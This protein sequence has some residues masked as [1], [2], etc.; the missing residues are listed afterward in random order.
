M[1]IKNKKSCEEKERRLITAALPYINNLP[2]L[3]HIVGSHLPADIFARYCRLRGYKTLFVGGTDENGSASEIVAKQVGVR[4]DIFCKRLHKEHK[5]IYDWF[6][7]S[8]DNF[9]RTSELIHHQTTQEFFKKIYK[10][11][12][13][14]KDKIKVFYSPEEKMFLPD[15]Y[16][17]GTCAKCGYEDAN[18]D[19]CEKC[20]SVLEV[21]QL[22]SPRSTIS[23]KPVEIRGTQHLFLRLDKLAK[24]LGRWLKEKN[25]WSPQV[26]SLALGWI[27]E[28]LKK[29]SITRD[30]KHGVKVPLKGFENKVFYVWFDAPIGYISSTKE[31]DPE[32][33]EIWWKEK[34]SKIYH[35]LGKDNIP[36]HT[37]FW[38]AMLIAHGEF[39]LP[40]YVVGLQYLN[41]EGKKFSK[42]KKWGVFCENLPKT[43]IDPDIVRAYLTLIIPETKDTEFRWQDFQNSINS[44]IIGNLGNFINRTLSFIYN[45]LGRKIKKP[46]QNELLDSDKKLLETIR[47][48]INKIEIYLENVK[49]RLAFLEILSLSAYGNKY[50][51]N[52]EPWH[53][54]KKDPIRA[55]HI[56]YLCANLCKTLAILI[57][58]YLP[59]ISQKIW[60]Q[61]N[62]K[63][64]I[65]SRGIW[66][67]LGDL[68]LPDSHIINKPHILFKK[69][70]NKDWERFKK[71]VSETKPLTELF[72]SN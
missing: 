31:A 39:N 41:F 19:Q 58:P 10:N 4:I 47:K 60:K 56:L 34:N 17:K 62:L 72:N 51:N 27:R 48:K 25:Y 53:V 3:G 63:E 54:I 16:V 12:F 20:T 43:N 29:R 67:S 71:I 52:N 28:G 2:H 42:S 49:L 22:L 66:D 26:T 45:K 70:S 24:K 64:K 65:G 6:E 55:S 33:W 50:L 9:S 5:K 38:P 30:L 61:L 36:F 1:R 11:G 14:S 21:T 40:Y 68:N 15:R 7:I 59:N 32:N 69:F 8:Y 44:E 35:F 13:V 23:G 37:I 46:S 18:A 57:H